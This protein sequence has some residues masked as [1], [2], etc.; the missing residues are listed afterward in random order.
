VKSSG[1]LGSGARRLRARGVFVAVLL[2]AVAGGCHGE[3]NPV[4][5]NLLEARRLA[6]DLRVQFN[7]ASNASDRAV[8]ADTD[9]ASVAFAREA[10]RL[11]EWTKR[12]VVELEARLRDLGHATEVDALAAFGRHFAEYEKVDHDILLLAIENTNLKAQRLSFG[13]A[14]DEA[15]AFRDALQ[16]AAATVSHA[17]KA[18]CGVDAAVAKGVLA[19]REI[20]ILQAPHIA[21]ADDAVMARLEKEMADREARARDASKVIAGLVDAKGKASVATALEALDKFAGISKEIV[22]LSRRN[23]NVRSL[24]LSLRSKPALTAACDDSLRVLEEA[25]A[26]EA[27][28]ATR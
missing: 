14:R 13:P 7:K 8:L 12:D 22:K 16:A 26:K 11:T 23:T 15:D 5:S 24:E 6:A 9:E 4:V 17:S 21:E 28:P 10:D 27:F 18:G 2:L 3:V 19:V 25:L 20:Q 1:S